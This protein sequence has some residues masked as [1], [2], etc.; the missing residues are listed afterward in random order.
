[1]GP[2][3]GSDQG[4]LY[5]QAGVID[6][7]VVDVKVTASGPYKGK[8]SKNGVIGSL[9]RLNV[10][11]GNSVTLNFQVLDAATGI[12]VNVDGMSMTFLDIDEGKNGKGRASVTACGGQQ[13]LPNPSELTLS[14][15][16]TCSTASS[17]VAG[18]S[19]DNPSSVD[20]ALSSDVASK[21]VVSYVF[22]PANM[23]TVTLD[24][25]KGYGFR[26]FMFALVPGAACSDDSNLPAAC[27]AALAAE[28]DF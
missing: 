10:K 6:G 9:G 5:P 3:T 11:T 23:F 12:A 22:A 25:A 13:F 24:V 26:N 14:A 16:G 18:T 7:Q 28:E 15:T 2:D 27:A 21:R 4:I 19:A 20:A 17:S 8:G 1:M